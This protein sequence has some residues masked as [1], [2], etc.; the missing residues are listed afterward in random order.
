MNTILL[1]MKLCHKFA[2]PEMYLSKKTAFASLCKTTQKDIFAI[3]VDFFSKG[4]QLF[5]EDK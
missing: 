5:I 4:N 2:N 3:D 1:F